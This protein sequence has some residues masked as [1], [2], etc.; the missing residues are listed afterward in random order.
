MTFGIETLL[1]LVGLLLFASAGY[2]YWNGN[3]D[4]TFV[5]GVVGI[6]AFFVAYRFRLKA[7]IAA[8]ESELDPPPNSDN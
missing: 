5:A 6:C 7:A 3:R 8:H 4:G 1:R 2:F